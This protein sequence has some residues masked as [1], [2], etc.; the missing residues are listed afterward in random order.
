M[1]CQCHFIWD[2]VILFVTTP[3]LIYINTLAF[4]KFLSK[5]S[6]TET[7]STFPWSTISFITPF[8]FNLLRDTIFCFVAIFIFIFVGLKF[9]LSVI[10]FCETCGLITRRQKGNTSTGFGF[11]AWTSNRCIA[12][13]PRHNL[14]SDVIGHWSCPAFVIY[15]QWSKD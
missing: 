11:Y 7:V 3:F 2:I 1:V 8:M 14:R 10:Y 12:T 15:I 9:A 5:F 4:S 13:N 6:W